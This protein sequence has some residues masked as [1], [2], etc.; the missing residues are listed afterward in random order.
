MEAR[1]Y[2]KKTLKGDLDSKVQKRN[3]AKA[4]YKVYGA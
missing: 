3:N 1:F 4:T 2:M